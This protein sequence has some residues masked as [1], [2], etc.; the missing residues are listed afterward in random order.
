MEVLYVVSATILAALFLVLLSYVIS[1][2][3]S[4]AHFRT[5]LEYLRSVLKELNGGNKHD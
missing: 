1:R 4:F 5:R 2:A 3:A